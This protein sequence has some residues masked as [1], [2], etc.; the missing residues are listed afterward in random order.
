MSLKILNPGSLSLIQDS[1]RL[2]YQGIGVAVGGPMDEHAF[3]WANR[4]LDNRPTAAQ[5]EITLGG[6]QAEFTQEA[7]IAL[8]GAD[9]QADLNGTRLKLWRTHHVPAGSILKCK[10]MKQGMRAYLAVQGG[11]IAPEVLGSC[12]TVMRDELGGL[13]GAGKSLQKGDVIDYQPSSHRLLRQVPQAFIPRYFTPKSELC[14]L[15][16]L[17]CYQYSDF[18]LQERQRFFRSVYQV[19]PNSDRMGYRLAGD[20][21]EYAGES[22]ISEG[23]ALGAIQIPSDGQP[24]VLMADHQ[25]IGGYPKIGCLTRMSVS[26][27]AQCPPGTKIRFQLIDREQAEAE[28]R[29]M[30]TFFMPL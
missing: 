12:A 3:A 28:Y 16:V 1:G 18:S 8:T 14:I 26:K 23:I 6:F 27:L 15:D 5:I 20:N 9:T 11:F 22:L 19:T 4:L 21:I 30:L 25:T 24:I 17:A 13:E 2:G 7:H 29:K 10:I